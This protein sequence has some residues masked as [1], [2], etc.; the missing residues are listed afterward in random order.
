MA[1]HEDRDAVGAARGRRCPYCAWRTDGNGD[2]RIGYARARLQRA[3]ELPDFELEGRA[4]QIERQIGDR[5][6]SL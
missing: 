6:R 4:A 5:T 3:E 2:F 1:R